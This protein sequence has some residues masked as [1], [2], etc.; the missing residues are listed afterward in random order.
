MKQNEIVALLDEPAR[1]HHQQSKSGQVK[2]KP[3]ATAGG[4]SF[5][6]APRWRAGLTRP[7]RELAHG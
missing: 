2:L 6:G 1:E 5:E 4:C 3:G 7:A